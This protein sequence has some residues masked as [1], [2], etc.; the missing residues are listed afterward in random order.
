MNEEEQNEIKSPKKIPLEM[1]VEDV[2]E[3]MEDINQNKQI[4]SAKEKYN[5]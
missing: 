4:N 2:E 3:E 1:N 5:L